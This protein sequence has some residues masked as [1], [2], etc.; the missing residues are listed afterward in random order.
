MLQGGWRRKG[1][2]RRG[3][4]SRGEMKKENIREGQQAGSK[5]RKEG[6]RGKQRTDAAVRSS[7]RGKVLCRRSGASLTSSLANSRA[8]CN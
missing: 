1:G 6:R 3:E 2:Q 8:L 5:D 4:E 7:S